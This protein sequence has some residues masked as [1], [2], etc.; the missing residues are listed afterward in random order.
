MTEEITIDAK[1]GKEERYKSLIPQLDALLAGE[2]DLIANL[3][4]LSA[5]LKHA[6]NFLWVGFYFHKEGELVLGPFQG[7]V[8]CNRL[9]L[10]KGVCGTAVLKK[11]PIIVPDVDLF[12]G[13]IACSSFAKSE[14]VLPIYKNNEVLA[15][16][17]VDSDQLNSFDEI[18]QK[19]LSAIV[20]LIESKI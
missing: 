12:E 14:I 7:P 6:F 17:D 18:D 11:Q 19:F 16:L 3:A 8:A 13:H 1:L 10:G 20:S 2:T 5:A 4:N 9:Q 15:V